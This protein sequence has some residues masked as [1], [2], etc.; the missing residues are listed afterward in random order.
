MLRKYEDKLVRGYD[1]KGKKPFIVIASG[2]SLTKEDV[3]YV[4]GKGTVIVINDNYKMAPWADYL[5]FCDPKWFNWH[6]EEVAKFQGAIYTQDETIAKDN[7][8][9]YI[10]SQ[11]KEGLSKDPKVIYQGSNSGYQAINLAYHL[12][13]EQIILLGYDMQATNGKYHWFGDH[14][15]KVRSSYGSWMP[16]YKGLAKDAEQAGLEVINC[17]RQTALSCFRREKLENVLK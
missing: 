12:G 3:E 11:S 17:S 7:G 4:K 5:Y 2:P 14:P 6:K 10:E 16:H 8:F 9:H 1:D 13:A 15:D